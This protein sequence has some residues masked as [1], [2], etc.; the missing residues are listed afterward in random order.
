M[1]KTRV[2]AVMLK[3]G[4]VIGSNV[5]ARVDVVVKNQDMSAVV[6]RRPSFPA[7]RAQAPRWAHRA[8][9]GPSVFAS[10]LRRV[11]GGH[12]AHSASWFYDYVQQ[13]GRE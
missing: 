1:K 2:T 12:R 9:L 8:R 3:V 4:V 5:I 6:R 13:S 10:G 7:T 11:V